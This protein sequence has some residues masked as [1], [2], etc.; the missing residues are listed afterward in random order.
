MCRGVPGGP[1]D[2]I[3]SSE[4]VEAVSGFIAFFERGLT[5]SQTSCYNAEHLVKRTLAQQPRCRK[6]SLMRSSTD[7]SCELAS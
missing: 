3:G 5:G 2:G 4:G 7:S 1:A 6:C